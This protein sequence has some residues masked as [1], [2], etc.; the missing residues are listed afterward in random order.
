MIAVLIFILLTAIIWALKLAKVGMELTYKVSV[1]ADKIRRKGA[2]ALGVNKNATTKQIHSYVN[3]AANSVRV[4]SRSIVTTTK[5]TLD[6]C[7]FIFKWMRGILIVIYGISLV[8]KAISFLAIV[9]VV[10]YISSVFS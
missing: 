4:L 1:K 9:G 3:F 6:V 8:I 10:N 5:L 7:I 2:E